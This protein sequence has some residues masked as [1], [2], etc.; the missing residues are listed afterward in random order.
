MIHA[1]DVH[2]RAAIVRQKNEVAREA[3]LEATRK[4]IAVTLAPYVKTTLNRIETAITAAMEKG[5]WGI[6]YPVKKPDGMKEEIF[7]AYRIALLQPLR[8]AGFSAGFPVNNHKRNDMS[9][10][11]GNTRV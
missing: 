10:S 5:G 2:R 1:N 7:P 3:A 11:W 9:I 4:V 6:E 8:D